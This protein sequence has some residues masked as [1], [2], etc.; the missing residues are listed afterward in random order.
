MTPAATL[1]SELDHLD[2]LGARAF[3]GFQVRKDLVRTGEEELAKGRAAFFTEEWRNFLIRL[4][5]L[6]PTALAARAK[7]VVLLRMAPFVARCRTSSAPWKFP[8]LSS[9]SCPPPA[10][11]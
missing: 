6:E 8:A 11:A 1:T 5:G 4:I 9:E 7:K 2:Q 3:D 10:N